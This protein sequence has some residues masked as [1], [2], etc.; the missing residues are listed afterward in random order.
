MYPA[1]DLG[2]RRRRSPSGTVHDADELSVKLEYHF[3]GIP[4]IL[5]PVQC[6][7]KVK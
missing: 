5:L 7:E 4:G 6:D 3:A 2:I 1:C